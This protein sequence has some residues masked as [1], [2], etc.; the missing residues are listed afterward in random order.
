MK[1]LF[2]SKTSYEILGL[3]VKNQG[4]R[5]YLSEIANELGKDPAN[6]SRELKKMIDEGIMAVSGERKKYYEFNKR[7]PFFL[8]LVALFKKLDESDFS[9]KFSQDWFLGEEIMN[10]DPFFSQIW[11]RCFVENFY[12]ATGRN[13]KK[14]AAIF[15]GYHLWFYYGK[16]DSR[17]V[18][19]HLVNRFLSEPDYMA[20]VNGNI[21][22]LSDKLRQYAEKLP[23]TDL[24][25]I[26]AKKLW[27]YYKN[28]EDLH[29]EYYQWGWIPVAADMFHN[30]LTDRGKKILKELKAPAGKI[31]EI[32]ALLTQPVGV[33]LIRKEQEE[34]MEI[35]AEVQ[36]DKKQFALFKEL[37]RKFKEEDVKEF[38]LYT[39]SPE[40]ERQFERAVR[41]IYNQINPEILGKIES[42]YSKYFYT[43]FI[44]T[45]EQGVYSF[46]HFLKSLVR[47]VSNDPNVAGTLKEERK[48]FSEKISE[49]KKLIKEMKLNKKL[50][51]FFDEW[52]NFMVTKIYRR[53]AQLFALYRMVPILTEIGRRLGL[54]LKQLKFMT[55]EEIYDSLFNN[56][57]NAEE[58]KKRVYFSVFYADKNER[59]FYSGEEA[60]K[61][62][63]YIEKDEVRE[64]KEI[65]G[66]CGA[67]GYAKG[68]VKIVNVARDMEKMGKGDI[69]V[70]IS[71][72]PDLLP[73]MKKAAAF[74]T[75]QGGVTSHAAIVA[76]EINTP[77]VIGTK[78]A[79]K[80]LKDGDEVEIDADKGVVKILK[81]S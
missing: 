36:A 3:F 5:F 69:L 19:E 56:K 25:K 31:E 26:T 29:R 17:E 1:S 16:K 10:V 80:V 28:H 63:K 51:K 46:E 12:R 21:I 77:C 20:E 49:R 78:I 14:I 81:K 22:G 48:R 24:K 13:Y 9:K 37:F 79:T 40:Y 71:T 70:S 45:E 41:L 60:K 72:Q 54:S 68:V 65:K 59:L 27:E 4:K 2:N 47:L 23:E 76:R 67:R 11:L 57:I 53:Y 39:H 74:I 32:L 8:E 7:C 73:A 62:V 43:K 50:I 15:R 6:I 30:N 38:G 75:D 52:G 55:S 34:L 33:S 35:G 64:V 44:Y 42:H 18:G 66:Q 58:I 61:I